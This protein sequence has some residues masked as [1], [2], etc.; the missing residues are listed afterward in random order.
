MYNFITKSVFGVHYYDSI[1]ILE[2][3]KMKQ[4]ESTMKGKETL[5]YHFKDFGHTKKLTKIIRSL[6]KL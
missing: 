2:K 5:S 6:L 3:R 4:P 1:I